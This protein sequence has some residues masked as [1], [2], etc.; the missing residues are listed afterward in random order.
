MLDS[1][2]ISADLPQSMA[3]TLTATPSTDPSVSPSSG[4]AASIAAGELPLA[5]K[6]VGMVMFSSYPADP[7]PRR[8]ADALIKSGASVEL[9]CL[10]DEGFRKRELLNGVDVRRVAV[11][12]RRAGKF[13]YAYQY[14][15]FILISAAILAL[16][17]LRRRYDLVYVHNMPDILV[18]S[19]LIPKALGAKVILDLHDPMPELMTTI[20]GHDPE[21]PK[22]RVDQATREVEPGPR[23]SGDHGQHCVQTYL[24][25][26]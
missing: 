10:R 23:Q 1:T 8:A 3:N 20:F 13:A 4:T 2:K 14:S 19:A 16:R 25:L 9:I 21:Q 5:G 15:A 22:C 11:E 18:L 7:R 12:Q 26:T 6:R 17:S 24:R